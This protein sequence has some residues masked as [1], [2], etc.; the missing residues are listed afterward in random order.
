MKYGKAGFSVGLHLVHLQLLFCMF[1]EKMENM[2]LCM[3]V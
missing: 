3:F 2:S 1:E